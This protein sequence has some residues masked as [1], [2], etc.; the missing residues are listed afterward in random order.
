MSVTTTQFIL[1]VLAIIAMLWGLYAIFRGWQTKQNPVLHLDLPPD[2]NT[3]DIGADSATK[4]E[5]LADANSPN[6]E[7]IPIIPRH[8]R[9]ISDSQLLDNPLSQTCIDEPI[10]KIASQS[11][12]DS[13]AETVVIPN[14]KNIPEVAT[15]L[16]DNG[17]LSTQAGTTTTITAEGDIYVTPIPATTTAQTVAPTTSSVSKTL[18]NHDV[19]DLPIN[20]EP[21]AFS[22]LA[23]ATQAITPVVHT[24][25]ESQLTSEVFGKNS[26]ILDT[27]IQAQIDHEQ[28]SPLHNAE[29]NINISIFPHHQ[30]QRFLGKDLLGLVDKYGL[31]Y[32]AMNMFHRYEN[33]DGTGVLWFS[34]MMVDDQTP[35]AFDLNKL[36]LQHLD[37]LIL[38]LSLP[39]PEAGQAFESMISMAK[40]MAND[41]GAEL[42]DDVGEPLSS[43]SISLLKSIAVLYGTQSD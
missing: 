29:Q 31:K 9:Q 23:N 28:N 40:M 10:D 39:H 25:D 26:P 18:A 24:F 43:D 7:G 2:T 33:K 14:A 36:P 13:L 1:M 16:Q 15:P 17:V 20:R 34:M 5:S 22:A 27:H 41:L 19:A 8:A 3:G 11:D 6:K 4:A 35:S 12:E 42:Y 30:L 32:G 38:F 37:G 21:D